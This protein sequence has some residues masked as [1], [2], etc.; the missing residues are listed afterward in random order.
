MARTEEEKKERWEEL[1]TEYKIDEVAEYL[2]KTFYDGPNSPETYHSLAENI[3]SLGWSL[4]RVSSDGA[5][6]DCITARPAGDE[7]RDAIRQEIVDFFLTELNQ[8]VE[9]FF[10][11]GWK[12]HEDTADDII[13]AVM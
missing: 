2:E 9:D 8:P 12:V 13:E 5:G 6:Y 11:T 4:F 1:E 10:E 7:G 3:V